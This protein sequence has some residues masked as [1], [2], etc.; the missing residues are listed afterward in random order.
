M[1]NNECVKGEE[2]EQVFSGSRVRHNWFADFIILFRG[3]H[4]LYNMNIKQDLGWQLFM[5]FKI[6]KQKYL[7]DNSSSLSSRSIFRPFPSSSIPPSVF[8]KVQEIRNFFSCRGRRGEFF[9]SFVY[10][11]IVPIAHNLRIKLS[12]ETT[13]RNFSAFFKFSRFLAA[14]VLNLFSII[15]LY[16]RMGT[17]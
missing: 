2:V 11:K 9:K 14:V 4:I 7:R 10:G 17:N 3:F 6:R 8:F 1:I 13:V 5:N 16:A 12:S 15:R